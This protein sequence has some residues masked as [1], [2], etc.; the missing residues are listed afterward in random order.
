MVIFVFFVKNIIISMFELFDMFIP[1][2]CIEVAKI[3]LKLNILF[4][5]VLEFVQTLLLRGILVL[6]HGFVLLKQIILR[7]QSFYGVALLIIIEP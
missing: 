4:F 1:I 7:M 5:Y 6:E 3:V 2:I